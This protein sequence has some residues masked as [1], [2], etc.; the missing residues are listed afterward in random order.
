MRSTLGSLLIALGFCLAPASSGTAQEM[1]TFEASEPHTT[2][3]VLLRAALYRPSGDGPFPAVVLMHGCGGWQPA[4]RY[5]LQV[6]ARHL[7]SQG[8]VVLNLDSFGPRNSSGGK[9]CASN[10]ALYTALSYRT[11]DA[12]DA[13]AYLQRLDFVAADNVFLMGQS[14]GGAV[15]IRAAKQR[16]AAA[17]SRNAQPF[18][19]IVA[20]YPWCGE[21]RSRVDLASPLLIFAGG[22]DDW[23]P[24][25]ECQ[26]VRASGAKLQVRVYPD[27][28]HSFDLDI[29]PQ[30]YL[31]KLIGGDPQATRDSRARMLAF[32]SQNM[33]RDLQSARLARE[34]PTTVTQNIERRAER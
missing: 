31:G 19:A 10:R 14:N 12:F 32:F 21:L 17:K 22:K 4:V 13:L 27:A 3:R 25:H 20:Y 33:T 30:R 16:V 34:E 24:A 11:E 15:A 8:F 5:G 18:R 1:V 6:H 2:D 26:G 7:Q 9:L 23:V 29:I 28:A